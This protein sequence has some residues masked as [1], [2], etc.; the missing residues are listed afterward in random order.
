MAFTQGA[1]L[2]DIKETTTTA[3]TAPDYYK[4]GRAHV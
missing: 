4:I 1:P 3:T 2:P